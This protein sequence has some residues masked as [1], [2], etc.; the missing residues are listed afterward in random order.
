MAKNIKVTKE[1][2]TGLNQEFYDPAK[3]KTMTRGEFVQEIKVGN[4]PDYNV[5]N[6]DGKNIPR[7]NPDGSTGNN[8]D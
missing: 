3:H 6:K 4:Y 1:T 5:M 8:L 2:G 7:S